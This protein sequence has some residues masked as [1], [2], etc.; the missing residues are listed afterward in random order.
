MNDEKTPPA[1]APAPPA[2]GATPALAELRQR[3]DKVDED[4]V[5]LLAERLETV[6]LVI[7]EKS[8]RSAGIRVP[9][10]EREVLTRVEAMARARGISGPLAR[11]VFADII[12]HSVTRQASTLSARDAGERE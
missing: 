6:A 1:V 11:K 3:L 8:G 10:R 5:R 7:K 9:E 2:H 12:E 4:I